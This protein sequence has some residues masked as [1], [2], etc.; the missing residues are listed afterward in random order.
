MVD[1]CTECGA[2]EQDF[3]KQGEVEICSVC[4]MED[5]K[6]TYNENEEK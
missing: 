1:V 2:T 5:S 4:G 3:T 6:K